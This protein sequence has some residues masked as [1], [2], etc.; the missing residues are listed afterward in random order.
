MRIA[1]E[2]HIF[3]L[4]ADLMAREVGFHGVGLPLECDSHTNVGT[5]HDLC[6]RDFER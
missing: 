5:D 2:K 4:L 6:L 1:S 3:C